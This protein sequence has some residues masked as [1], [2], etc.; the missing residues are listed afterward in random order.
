M[1]D[2]E[3][4][5]IMQKYVRHSLSDRSVVISDGR[6]TGRQLKIY[7]RDGQLKDKNIFSLFLTN[8]CEKIKITHNGV[9]LDGIVIQRKTFNPVILTCKNE[10]ITRLLYESIDDW[11]T[12]TCNFKEILDKWS[13]CLLNSIVRC[14]HT[15]QTKKAFIK[16]LEI[17][18]QE[19]SGLLKQISLSRAII[20]V[21]YISY[22]LQNG[23]IGYIRL[24]RDF[25][26]VWLN[27][28]N[29][30]TVKNIIRA[31]HKALTNKINFFNGMKPKQSIGIRYQNNVN[32][33][34]CILQI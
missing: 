13:M 15:L 11:T 3:Q 2:R 12:V 28:W 7:S 10:I 14:V 25:F 21:R 24:K 8:P 18:R 31:R 33:M 4:T 17:G 30:N 27:Y 9:E 16:Q 29:N 32:D 20:S 34:K 1:E 26:S 22:L 5:Y 6:K 23:V 19:Q